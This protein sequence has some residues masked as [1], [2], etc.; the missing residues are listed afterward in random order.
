MQSETIQTST[1][2]RRDRLA[3]GLPA[4]LPSAQDYAKRLM[5]GEMSFF[6]KLYNDRFATTVEF[7]SRLYTGKQS[8]VLPKSQ[9]ERILEN[10]NS[11]P[12]TEPLAKLRAVLFEEFT[13]RLPVAG[14]KYHS[15]YVLCLQVLKDMATLKLREGGIEAPTSDALGFAFVE[16]LLVSIVDHQRTAQLSKLLPHLSCWLDKPS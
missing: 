2:A 3:I 4:R 1:N 10:A 11:T 6:Y 9:L 13:G 5:P 12:F 7:W 16:T 14:I 15:I 8:T